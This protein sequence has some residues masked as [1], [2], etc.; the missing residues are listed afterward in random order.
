MSDEDKELLARIGQ[1]AGMS[2]RESR[3]QIHLLNLLQARL[4]DTRRSS[5][6]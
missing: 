6:E 4:I 1:L 3:A 5:L 2:T